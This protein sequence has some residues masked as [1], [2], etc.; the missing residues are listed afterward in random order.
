MKENSEDMNAT[1]NDYFLSVFTHENLTT[2]IDAD[3]VFRGKEDVR[4]MKLSIT[5]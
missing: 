3:L 2:L 1:L 4:S 5:S